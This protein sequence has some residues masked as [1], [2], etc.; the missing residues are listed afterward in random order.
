MFNSF[1]VEKLPER[2]NVNEIN[3][4]IECFCNLANLKDIEINGEKITVGD[5]CFAGSSLEKV[6]FIGNVVTI[7][8]NCFNDCNSLNSFTINYISSISIGSQQFTNC[9]NLKTISVTFPEYNSNLELKDFELANDC[10]KGA[11]NLDIFEICAKKLTISI[12]LLNTSSISSLTIKYAI[13][14]E[15][16]P[17]TINDSQNLKEV[18]ITSKS[19]IVNENCFNGNHSLQS[20]F[21]NCS[22]I[23][24]YSN[25]F[26]NIDNC[27]SIRFNNADFLTFESDDF[28][29]WKNL[30]DITLHALKS[31]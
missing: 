13:D 7:S 12:K 9:T 21:S 3:L 30:T 10:F 31:L 14:D 15:I 17:G 11:D 27:N 4:G 28:C 29:F 8:N 20:V 16:S 6:L 1:K 23:Y 26:N 25:C 18:S 22:N 24:F 5:R 19:L 2:E